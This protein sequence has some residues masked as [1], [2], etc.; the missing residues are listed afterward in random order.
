MLPI[1]G[2]VAHMEY[3]C[4]NKVRDVMIKKQILMTL[5]IPTIMGCGSFAHAASGQGSMSVGILDPLEMNLN[6]ATEFCAEFGFA[7]KC[8]IIRERVIEKKATNDNQVPDVSTLTTISYD[9]DILN[10]NFE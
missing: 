9:Y 8:E 5:F 1:C 10:A 7:E 4:N 2:L 6:A 3:P